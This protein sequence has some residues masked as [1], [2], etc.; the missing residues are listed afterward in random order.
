MSRPL[1]LTPASEVSNGR[2]RA[3]G[4]D[5]RIPGSGGRLNVSRSR[6]FLHTISLNDFLRFPEAKLKTQAKFQTPV[7]LT[8]QRRLVGHPNNWRLSL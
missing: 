6:P 7:L 5:F 1:Q 2:Q 8:V 4:R 3:S